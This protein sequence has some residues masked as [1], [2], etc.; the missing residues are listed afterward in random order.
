MRTV[1]SLLGPSVA[2]GTWQ[3]T[4]L[5]V[6]FDVTANGT[7]PTSILRN[8]SPA[9]G[10]KRTSLVHL[11]PRPALHRQ[12]S[13]QCKG[14]YAFFGGAVLLDNIHSKKGIGNA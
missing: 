6:R 3:L 1:S 4:S 9:S 2:F 13:A 7:W 11:P 10:I 14:H 12:T 5:H 8:M